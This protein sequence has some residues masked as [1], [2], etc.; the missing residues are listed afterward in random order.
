MLES[1]GLPELNP[2]VSF[3][4]KGKNKKREPKTMPLVEN[5]IM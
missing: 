1:V 5:A 4:P 2:S 3:T